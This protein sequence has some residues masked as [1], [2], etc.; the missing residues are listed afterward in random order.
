MKDPINQVALQA[1]QQPQAA[2]PV[3]L[4]CREQLCL[5]QLLPD[6]IEPPNI[7]RVEPGI[8]PS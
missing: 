4:C 6:G 2:S 1:W 8:E 5:H 3:A 7:A